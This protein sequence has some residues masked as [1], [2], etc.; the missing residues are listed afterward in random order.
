[1]FTQFTKSWFVDHIASSDK[2]LAEY[3]QGRGFDI[4]EPFA[5]YSLGRHPKD[6]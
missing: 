4:E 1:L 5:E 2:P 6:S 3:C